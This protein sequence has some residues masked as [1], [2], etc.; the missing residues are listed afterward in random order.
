MNALSIFSLIA[1]YLP[2]VMGTVVAV[3]QSVHA[4]GETKATVALNTIQAVSTIA[5]QTIPEQH[6]QLISGLI[7]SVVDAFN[8]SGVFAKGNPA[9]A[10]AGTV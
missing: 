6:V 10:T 5:G 1:K 7:N 9:P 4:P 2:V 3:E 8:K